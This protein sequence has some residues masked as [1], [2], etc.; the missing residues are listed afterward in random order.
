MHNT[1]KER[2]AEVRRYI[3]SAALYMREAHHFVLAP[4]VRN[5]AALSSK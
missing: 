1:Q 5:S 4:K 3:F 2:V